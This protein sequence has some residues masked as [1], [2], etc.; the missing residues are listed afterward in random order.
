M[1]VVYLPSPDIVLETVPGVH[2]VSALLYSLL[3][4]MMLGSLRCFLTP[5]PLWTRTGCSVS[6]WSLFTIPWL[7]VIVSANVAAGYC[8]DPNWLQS[9]HWLARCDRTLG[10]LT[11]TEQRSGVP[12]ANTAEK[13]SIQT[14]VHNLSAQWVVCNW[15]G[16]LAPSN[17]P[18]CTW[19]QL[20]SMPG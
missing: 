14:L 20:V 4:T 8:Y 12:E 10:S 9:C 17:C 5:S 3:L 15:Y 18:T 7:L 1:F 13:S 6:H 2:G 19:R 11:T 16:S